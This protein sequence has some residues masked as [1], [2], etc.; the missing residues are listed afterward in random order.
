MKKSVV[1]Y[2][3]KEWWEDFGKYKMWDGEYKFELPVLY[4]SKE[5]LRLTEYKEWRK[6]KEKM[7]DEYVKITITIES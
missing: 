7:F 2:A 1:M 5:N 3:R 6:K 4:G